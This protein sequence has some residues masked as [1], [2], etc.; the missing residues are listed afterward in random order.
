MPF[1]MLYGFSN[2]LYLL[3]YK[4]IGYRKEVVRRNLKAAFPN[5]TAKELK[6]IEQQFYSYLFD[7]LLESIKGFSLSEK[8]LLRRQKLISPRV[9]QA[10]LEK[11]NSTLV[12][13]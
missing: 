3:L 6:V 9:T 8:E 11:G 5:K 1:W 13:G 2:F 7:L 12:V 10:M 4:I